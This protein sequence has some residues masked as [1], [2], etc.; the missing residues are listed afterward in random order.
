MTFEI[1]IAG[2]VRQVTVEPIGEAASGRFRV[3]VDGQA[4]EVDARQTDLGLS[5]LLPDGRVVDAA[6]TDGRAGDWLVQLPH[7][8]LTATVD[9]RRFRRGGPGDAGGSGEQRITAPM[10]GRV[11][12]VLVKPGDEVRI[13]E[14]SKNI[15]P[16]QAALESK[17]RPT[18]VRWLAMDAA[19]RVGR[20]LERP[21]RAD[22][23]LAAQEQ[24][25]V[26]LYSK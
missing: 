10:P 7:V 25:I 16:V 3:V 17:T 20:M 15:V 9:G 22:I 21:S 8:S 2:S 4:V 6:L 18:T 12:R 26:E 1:D 13:R 11:V 23:P 14:A 5:L 19:T 24:L